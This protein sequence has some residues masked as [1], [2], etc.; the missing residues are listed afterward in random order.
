MVMG[1]LEYQIIETNKDLKSLVTFIFNL[2]SNTLNLSY[3]RVSMFHL[4]A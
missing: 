2:I 3:E 1:I 4:C